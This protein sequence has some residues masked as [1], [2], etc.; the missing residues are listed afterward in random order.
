MSL[1]KGSN[2]KDEALEDCKMCHT[3][4]PNSRRWYSQEWV[5]TSWWTT[6]FESPAIQPL[7]PP[8]D[9]N[10]WS[11][12]PEISSFLPQ[13]KQEDFKTTVLEG[14]ETAKHQVRVAF[15]ACHLAA[16]S[17]KS[18]IDAWKYAWGGWSGLSV[19]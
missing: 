8:N 11:K 15:D 2:K 3:T 7:C 12:V 10:L 19:S 13:G 18:G 4:D 6:E 16:R 17:P 9:F 1:T 5:S 14:M